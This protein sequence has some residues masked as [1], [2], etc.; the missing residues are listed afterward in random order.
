MRSKRRISN[1]KKTQR[2]SR[3]RTY[4]RRSQ[5]KRTITKK[6]R[7]VN[8]RRRSNRKKKSK[9]YSNKR[10]RILRGGMNLAEFDTFLA[11]P[12]PAQAPAPAPAPVWTDP[13][14]F[15]TSFET[16]LYDMTLDKNEEGRYFLKIEGGQESMHM[17]DQFICGEIH[18]RNM[19]IPKIIRDGII[20]FVG[21][22]IQN[23]NKSECGRAEKEGDHWILYLN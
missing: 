21:R 10:R 16:N 7:R 18:G 22:D 14:G 8:R 6:S 15:Q 13:I 11:A 17:L 20:K 5:K 4:R 19:P 2:R 1:R 9:R 12:A 3:R 23:I